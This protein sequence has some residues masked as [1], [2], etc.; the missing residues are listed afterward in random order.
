MDRTAAEAES[1]RYQLLAD[2]QNKALEVTKV[3]LDSVKAYEILSLSESNLATHKR[4]YS[5]IKKRVN[6]GIGSTADL[7]QVEARLAKAHGN[8]AA[9]QNNLF[10]SH[11]MFTRLVGQTP[12]SLI[13][14]RADQTQ[15]PFTLDEA[16][17]QA[18]NQ[19]PVIKVS[20]VDVDSARY[21]Y[22]QTKG[23]NYPNVFF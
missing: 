23:R 8:L 12:Q 5:D 18:F 6:S 17:S 4:I 3:Y 15:I 20:Q 9:A 16:V 21:Q 7:S 11:T 19:H 13:F 22:K 10:D 1:L 14:P 2:A